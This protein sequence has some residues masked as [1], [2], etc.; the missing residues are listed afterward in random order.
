MKI[1]QNS[2]Y[3][4]DIW[5]EDKYHKSLVWIES[6]GNFDLNLYRGMLRRGLKI[7]RLNPEG[8]ISMR[9]GLK[10]NSTYRSVNYIL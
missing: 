7:M 5:A 1:T 3:N 8:Q 4:I 2:R 6:K 10:W 9:I